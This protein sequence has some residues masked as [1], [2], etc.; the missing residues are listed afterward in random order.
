MEA[1]EREVMEALEQ[2]LATEMEGYRFFI[3]AA[4]LTTDPK[5][6]EMFQIMAK[7]EID[8]FQSLKLLVSKFRD[9]GTARSGVKTE[10]GRK[11]IPILPPEE[12]LQERLARNPTETE[13]L[14]I[15]MDIESKA[16]EFYDGLLKKTQNKE[17]KEFLERLKHMERGHLTT[18]QG[19]YDSVSSSGFWCDHRE[20]SLE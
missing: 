13:A 8:H 16:V 17:I 1:K 19:E 14:K 6:K 9:K 15:G 7:D 2:A 20:F 18:L 4:A 11:G 5:G 12:S 10:T 3:A